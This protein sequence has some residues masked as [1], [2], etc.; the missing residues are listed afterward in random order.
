MKPSD[1]C[2]NSK[3]TD[4]ASNHGA[5]LFPL[6]SLAHLSQSWKGSNKAGFV[7]VVTVRT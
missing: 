7:G 2:L 3:L 4:G 5:V 6:D 1:S